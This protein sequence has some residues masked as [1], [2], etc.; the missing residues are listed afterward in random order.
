M[1]SRCFLRSFDA[2]T[3]AALL[4]F[5]ERSRF[6]LRKA[7]EAVVPVLNQHTARPGLPRRKK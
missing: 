7:V 3:H 5:P 4:T 2:W 1:A 6:D